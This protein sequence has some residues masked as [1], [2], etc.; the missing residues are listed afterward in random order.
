MENKCLINKKILITGVSSGIGRALTKELIASG[1]SVFGIARREKLLSSLQ[2]EVTN[3][4][5]YFYC[6]A[7]LTKKE[8]WKKIVTSFK[9]RKFIPDVVIFNAAILRNDLNTQIDLKVNREL[10]EANYFSILDGINNLLPLLKQGSQVIAISSLSSQKGSG[11]EG[12]GYSASKAA[13]SISFES[14]TQKFK[15]L[16]KFKIIFF[17]PI[18][19]GMNPFSKHSILSISENQAVDTLIDAI[20]SNKVFFYNPKIIFLV[21]NCIKLISQKIYFIL[22]DIID[23]MHDRNRQK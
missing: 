15:N 20:N 1:N 19:T 7:D 2:K 6:V 16:I 8:S 21:L 18:K 9:K 10:F 4:K 14:L 12:I 11:S 23:N 3:P 5:K 17:G 13:L 22:L